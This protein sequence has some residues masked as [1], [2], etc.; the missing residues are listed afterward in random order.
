MAAIMAMK[1][2]R[3]IVFLG[4]SL[5]LILMSAISAGFGIINRYF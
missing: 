1:F 2:S 3:G 5:A 4:S